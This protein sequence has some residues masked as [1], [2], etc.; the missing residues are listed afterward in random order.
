MYWIQCIQS[1]QLRASSNI[2]PYSH[3][4]LDWGY[5]TDTMHHYERGLSENLKN[6]PGGPLVHC[7][8]VAHFG[9][10]K[11]GF[12]FTRQ[13]FNWSLGNP[14]PA[15]Q[16]TTLLLQSASADCSSVHSYLQLYWVG[17]SCW[18]NPLLSASTAL[19]FEFNSEE[20]FAHVSFILPY[21]IVY[22]W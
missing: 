9:A 2:S 5:N 18:N 16:I 21:L 3:L 6:W 19:N 7:G 12:T 15:C 17:G 1:I 22:S 10:R 8:T 11:Q 20:T 13:V 4:L 14:A